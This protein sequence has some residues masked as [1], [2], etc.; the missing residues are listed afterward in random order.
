MSAALA[1]INRLAIDG[2][3]VLAGR[4]HLKEPLGSGGTAIVYRAWDATLEVERAVKLLTAAVSPTS[5]MGKRFLRE[6]RT[7]ARL[8]HPHILMVAD[9]GIQQD[10]PWMVMELL[11]GGSLR[12]VLDTGGPL[13][14]D[15]AISVTLALLAALDHAHEQDIV[16]RDVKPG[17]VL[18]DERGVAKLADFGLARVVTRDTSLTRTG[19]TMGTF[20]FMAP[21]QRVDASRADLRADV[22]GAGCTLFALLT[23][24]DPF[25]LC[26]AS[27]TDARFRNIPESVARVLLSSV[28]YRAE[29]RYPSAA[30]FAEAL[31]EAYGVANQGY[32][33]PLVFPSTP[34]LPPRGDGSGAFDLSRATGRIKAQ[35]PPQDGARTDPFTGEV[36]GSHTWCFDGEDR[37]TPGLP[38]PS[39]G[40]RLR[41]LRDS[42]VPKSVH[43]SLSQAPKRLG[44]LVGPLL[45][46]LI[47]ALVVLASGLGSQ[48]QAADEPVTEQV[49]P[50]VE[51]APAAAA[52]VVAEPASLAED[53]IPEL[54]TAGP[55]RAAPKPVSGKSKD[56]R[57]VAKP[58]TKAT[59][60][61][62]S[63]PF[64]AIYVDG[65]HVGTTPWRGEV[66]T[67]SRKVTLVLDSGQR[68][69]RTVQVKQGPATW[70]C[71]DFDNDSACA[72]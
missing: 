19:A 57:P 37:P 51:A 11:A 66:Q 53:P 34:S 54:E 45:A 41:R 42:I 12:H 3:V 9:A 69:S 25:D 68:K 31:T 18:I 36:T 7:M 32:L 47:G 48:R 14:L 70:T 61:V 65:K 24:Q 52:M 60:R 16:H 10:Q 2:E 26:M 27:P 59:L 39:V 40:Q 29:D 56:E 22:F 4:Y 38:R 46:A 13:P 33:P 44:Q 67:G 21:E 28:A 64:A 35:S 58:V 23:G 62:G 17:N 71:W 55:V 72:L 63:V 43:D 1:K 8:Q 20:A 50:L 49:Q 30:F 5:T 15:R 6:A